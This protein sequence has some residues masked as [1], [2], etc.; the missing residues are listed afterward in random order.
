MTAIICGSLAYDNIMVFPGRFSEEILPERVHAALRG[1]ERL[2]E[3][4][5]DA[6]GE[7]DIRALDDHAIGAEKPL[8]HGEESVRRQR[9][10]L[11]R[12]GVP[13]LGGLFYARRRLRG[14]VRGVELHLEGTAA[15]WARD[16]RRAREERCQR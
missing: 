3:G 6:R 12:E 16:A 14:G 11:V 9:R 10:G 8:N 15:R 1:G 5:E 4:G 2:G 13:D 7:G